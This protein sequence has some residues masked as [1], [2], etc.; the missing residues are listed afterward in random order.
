MDCWVDGWGSRVF[1][2]HAALIRALP[3]SIHPLALQL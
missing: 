2:A 1:G 3:S